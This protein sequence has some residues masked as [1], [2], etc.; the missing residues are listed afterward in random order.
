M[1]EGVRT[2]CIGACVMAGK[3]E[4][5]RRPRT[6]NGDAVLEHAGMMTG[7]LV[8]GRLA[9]ATKKFDSDTLVGPYAMSVWNPI[10]SSHDFP[11]PP[12]EGIAGGSRDTITQ[13]RRQARARH[14]LRN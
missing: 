14:L 6:G 3:G 11:L 12:Q 10:L 13:A 2:R 9:R 7:Y 5:L 8:Q 4:W 1:S